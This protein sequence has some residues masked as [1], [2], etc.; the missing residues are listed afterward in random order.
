[1]YPE[2]IALAEKPLRSDP[3]NQTMLQVAGVAYAKSGRRDDA[4]AIISR[5]KEI[6]RTQFVMSFYVA[7]IY[8]QL[9]EK[10]KAFAELEEGYQKHDWRMSALLKTEPLIESLRSDAR[11]TDLLKRLNLPQ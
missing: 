5:F 11:Y 6:A 3:N 2:A 1:M 8:A 7:T 10:D 4:N 9:G